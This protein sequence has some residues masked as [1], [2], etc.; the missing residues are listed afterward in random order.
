MEL[1]DHIKLINPKS[2]V[3][4]YDADYLLYRSGKFIG[5]GKWTQDRNVGD[6]FQS[7]K[8]NGDNVVIIADHW[9]KIHKS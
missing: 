4:E 2:P 5:I 3:L 6:S 7:K 1:Q 8:E 9:H